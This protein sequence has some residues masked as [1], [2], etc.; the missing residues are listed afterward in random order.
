MN[1]LFYAPSATL[2][3]HLVINTQAACLMSSSQW[4]PQKSLMFF[5]LCLK[6]GRMPRYTDNPLAP[7]PNELPQKYGSSGYDLGWPRSAMAW[8]MAWVPSKR[9][10][11]SW[12]W[13][14]Q[15]LATRPVVSGK[16]P[17]LSVLQKRISTKTENRFM[18]ARGWEQTKWGTTEQGYGFLLGASES[19]LKL[20]SAGGCT[21]L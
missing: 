6:F 14:R 11:E 5:K 9:Q 18:A 8:S 20:D 21:T 2:R 13:E 17:G 16:G 10:A 7:A 12:W 4:Y 3:P 15:I 1:F 19:V